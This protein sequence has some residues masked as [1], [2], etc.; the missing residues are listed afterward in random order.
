M[1]IFI[2]SSA[3]YMRGLATNSVPVT[4]MSSRWKMKVLK[5]S[6]LLDNSM[7]RD[8]FGSFGCQ[9]FQ[10]PIVELL[11]LE[12]KSVIATFRQIVFG[13]ETLAEKSLAAND[14]DCSV[15]ALW[16]YQVLSLAS[17]DEIPSVCSTLRHTML[18]HATVRIWD[19]AGLN[20][21]GTLVGL[22]RKDLVNTYCLIWATSPELLLW[23]LFMGGLASQG[24]DGHWWW[25]TEFANIAIKLSLTNWD[26][27][28]VVL[29]GFC[30]KYRTMDKIV[31]DLW[32]EA[33]QIIDPSRAT[34]SGRL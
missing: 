32:T 19:F 1:H 13:Y 25:V 6:S 9:F 4:P 28:L 17:A 29:E 20:C 26:G 12:V 15:L 5:E 30:F 8:N 2:L 23:V 31:D 24:R 21:T 22:L 27:L 3:E 18:V 11:E 16:G 33:L 10:S 7:T 14:V 34:V